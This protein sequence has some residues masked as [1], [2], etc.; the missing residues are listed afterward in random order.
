MNADYQDFQYKE[1]TEKIYENAISYLY[2]RTL[3]LL[4]GRK[5]LIKK[6]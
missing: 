2:E 4:R 1:V 6:L 5:W 3:R